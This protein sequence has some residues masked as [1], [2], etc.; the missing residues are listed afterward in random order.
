MRYGGQA[1]RDV[2]ARLSLLTTNEAIERLRRA[3]VPCGP[4]LLPDEVLSDPQVVATGAL[5][6]IP[7]PVLGRIRQPTPGAAFTEFGTPMR[8]RAAP[9]LGQ[10]TREILAECDLTSE[11]VQRL[12]ANRTVA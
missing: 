10:H 4:V 3:G 5:Q 1:M 9:T 11:Q 2:A 8:L 7:H 12:F 6:E